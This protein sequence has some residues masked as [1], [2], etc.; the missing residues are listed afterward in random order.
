MLL[1]KSSSVKYNDNKIIQCWSKIRFLSHSLMLLM[2]LRVA[3][4]LP[5]EAAGTQNGLCW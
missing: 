3:A 4:D 1:H 2:S 5:R